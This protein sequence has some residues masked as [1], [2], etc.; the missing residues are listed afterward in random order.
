VALSAALGAT[1][2]LEAEPTGPVVAGA[3]GAVLL[4]WLALVTWRTAPIPLA[5]GLLGAVY[6]IPVGDR[7][8]PAP[9]YGAGLLLCAELAYWSLESR[10]AHTVYGDVVTPRLLAVAGVAAASIPAGALALLAA[11]AGLGRSPALTAAAALAIAACVGLLAVLATVRPVR[12][13]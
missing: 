2:A 8:I 12:A 9:V 7:A 5:L 13:P 1:V 4:V 10:V 6:A 11:D 3:A